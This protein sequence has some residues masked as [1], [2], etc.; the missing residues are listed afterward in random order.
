[1]TER[2]PPPV[3]P[4][5]YTDAL[6]S[7]ESTVELVVRARD[8]DRMAVEALLQRCLPALT[9][10]AHGRLPVGGA[11]RP[12]YGRSGAGSGPARAAAP[13]HVRAAAR[14]RDAG[15]GVFPNGIELITIRA[16]GP[17]QWIYPC[18]PRQKSLPCS[19]SQ[20]LSAISDSAGPDRNDS[21]GV[22]MRIMR[23]ELWCAAALL[24]TSGAAYAA[25]HHRHD[26]GAIDRHPGIACPRRDDHRDVAQPTG[27]TRDRD[28]S[29]W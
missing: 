20:G 16:S 8:G 28:L 25:E 4:T 24:V 27:H 10:W 19:M 21:G 9:R 14:G 7:D 18:G 1:M 11:R 29:E 6:L 12:R 22:P 23:V 26:L 15:P 2:K 5:T 17:I 3:R 13:R